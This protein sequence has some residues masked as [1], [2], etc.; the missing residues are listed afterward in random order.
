MQSKRPGS[1]AKIVFA[2][3]VTFLLASII[4]P[5]QAQARKFKVLHT[6]HGA[7]DDGAIPDSKLLRDAAGNI[8]GTTISGGSAKGACPQGGCGTA[9][10][11]D[12][13]GKMTWLYR[14]NAPKSNTPEAGLL[15]DKAGH[16]YGT[17]VLGGDTKCYSSGCGTVFRLNSTGKKETVLYK[18]SGT[19]DG[20]MPT[21]PL[22]ED[23]AGNLYGTTYSGG[24]SGYGTV[25]KL[26]TTGNE[27][28][29]HSFA[30]PPSGGG[31]GALAYEGL[32]RDAAGNLYGVTAGGG[33]SGKGVVYKLDI[34]GSETLLYSF[35][36]GSDGA[37]PNSVL[38]PDTAG[39]LYGTTDRGGNGQCGGTGCGTVFELT[40]Q[41]GGTWTESILYVFCSRSN[42]ADGEFPQGLTLDAAGNVYGTTVFGGRYQNCNV[43]AC[44]VVFKLDA[45]GK[46]T[47]LHNFTG[48][49][50]GGGP[51]GPTA[52]VI[53]DSAGN[54]YGTTQIGGDPNCA[55]GGGQ[56]CGVVF[57]LTP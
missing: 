40:P 16:L 48:G 23:A 2:I 56:G 3:L 28:I 31:D 5:T 57:K 4:V 35:R 37:E 36:G 49:A 27:T 17:T 41:S 45:G 44:G 19:P 39:N 53:M 9:F 22:I 24:T 8:Y 38:V 11:M 33:A 52:R 29:L 13:A 1:K 15:R 51:G 46:E 20:S 12:K 50:D 6:F 7:P 47:V 55:A 42:C 18:F 26:D 54:L 30:G 21:A 25:F 14:F 10:K 43:D 34:A 32:T